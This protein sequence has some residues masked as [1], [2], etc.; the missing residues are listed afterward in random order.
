MKLTNFHIRTL[1]LIC[2]IA[3]GLNLFSQKTVSTF[4]LDTTSSKD[5]SRFL[6]EPFQVSSKYIYHSNDKRY[7]KF[8]KSNKKLILQKPTEKNYQKYVNLACALWEIENTIDAEKMF[9]T[10]INSTD[11]FYTSSYNHSSDIKGDTTHNTYGYGSF[12]SNYKNDAAIHLTKIYIEQKKFE[13]SLQYLEDAVKKYQ[14]IYNCGTGATMQKDQY[15]FLYALCYE[16]LERHKEVIDLLLPECLE[17]Q[18]DII[19][20]ALKKTYSQNEINEYLLKSEHSITC[21]LDT[22][23]S[24]AYQSYYVNGNTEKTD[25]LTYYS[26][27]ATIILFDKQLDMPRP[28]FENSERLTREYFINQFKKSYFYTKLMDFK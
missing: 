6:A 27:S 24:F 3:N 19:I 22:F 2:L 4:I 23:P 1:F 18:D 17:R 11:E 7:R 16:G 15:N 20:R 25:T 9:L 26:G 8:V 13:K 10:I 21:S 28:Y 14:V 5:P 12:T